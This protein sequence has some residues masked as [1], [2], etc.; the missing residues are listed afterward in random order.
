M[1]NHFAAKAVEVLAAAVLAGILLRIPCKSETRHWRQ[2]LHRLCSPGYSS[3]ASKP[4]FE[5]LRIRKNVFFFAPKIRICSKL[6][7]PFKFQKTC[8][9]ILWDAGAAGDEKAD[10]CHA[11]NLNL[12]KC[13]VP[14]PLAYHY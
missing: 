12:R 1:E 14:F 8:L 4:V 7:R 10:V 11:A 6:R 9:Q 13:C 3:Q 5:G 2:P